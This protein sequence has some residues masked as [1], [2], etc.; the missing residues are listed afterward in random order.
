M[1]TRGLTLEALVAE[2]FPAGLIDFSAGAQ[3]ASYQLEEEIGR[4]GMAV[5]Y[6]ARDVRLGRWVALKVLAPD[7]AQ[8]EA[9]RQ[10]FIRE[11]RTA[12]AVDHPNIIP[13]FDAG[14]AGRVLYIAMRYV[15]GQDV[16][17]LLHAA[18]PLAT[19]RALGIV[20]QVASALDAAHACGLVH[21]DVKPANMLLGGVADTGRADHVYLSDFGI[22][23]QLNATSSLTM[24]GQVLGTLNYLAPEQIEGRQVDGRADAYALACTAFELLAGSPPFRRDEN[25]AVMWAQLNAPPPALTSLRPDLPAAVDQVMA[26]ALAKAPADRFASCVAFSA[27]LQQACAATV[28][29]P[30]GTAPAAPVSPPPPAAWPAPPTAAD[31]PPSPPPS[32]PTTPSGMASPPAEP[33]RP[34]T[35]PMPVLSP[36]GAGSQ[37]RP[38]RGGLPP[39][40]AER[41]SGTGG[42]GGRPPGK[43]SGGSSPRASSRRGVAAVL[44]CVAVLAVG[45]GAYAV[46][47]NSA[48]RNGT[49][50]AAGSN[51][52]STPPSGAAPGPVTPV[53]TVQAYYAA[54]SRHQY[55]RAWNLGGKNSRGGVTFSQFEAGFSTTKADTVTILGHAGDA[56]TAR[57]AARQTDGSVKN[58]LGKYLVENGVITTFQVTQVN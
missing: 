10:R 33:R 46:L 8:D 37:A 52:P 1:S 34:A 6:R 22:S 9:F 38:E 24:T 51:G 17:S 21:R 26:R 36:P 55:L 40:G 43:Q 53:G 3:I 2:D 23:K 20:G 41:R 32:P 16:H 19:A 44:A 27:A 18:G 28:D 7:Y 11:S 58:F 49:P 30:A 48:L 4:G 31:L 13:I 56:V 45:G 12:A 29:A 14:E 47:H 5:V 57:L 54:I 35:T 15:P 25:M 42:S 50:A 39:L